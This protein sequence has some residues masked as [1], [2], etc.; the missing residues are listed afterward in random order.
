MNRGIKIIISFLLVTFILLNVKAQD[1]LNIEKIE[2][3]KSYRPLMGDALKTP[4]KPTL[5][6]ASKIENEV[7]Y[8]VPVV[9]FNFT[10]EPQKIKAIA[11]PK[12]KKIKFIPSHIRAGIGAHAST[13]LEYYYSSPQSKEYRY[14]TYFNHAALSGAKKIRNYSNNELAVF[15]EKHFDDFT[16]NGKVKYDRNGV[17]L[18]SNS[19]ATDSIESTPF[20][21]STVNIYSTIF[22]HKENKATIDYKAS[23]N[24]EM[25]FTNTAYKN[26]KLDLNANA[27]KSLAGDNKFEVDAQFIYNTQDLNNTQWE[28]MDFSSGFEYPSTSQSIL[29]SKIQYQL[30]NAKGKLYLGLKYAGDFAISSYYFFPEI[31]IGKSLLK[32]KIYSYNGHTGNLETNNHNYLLQMNPYLGASNFYWSSLYPSYLVTVN[33]ITYTAFKGNPIK[34]LHYDVKASM[35]NVRNLLLFVKPSADQDFAIK[36]DDGDIFN[37]HSE[38]SYQLKSKLKFVLVADYT[39]Y[40]LD[41]EEHA[42]HLPTISSTLSSYYNLQEKIIVKSDIFYQG[43]TYNEQNNAV[44]TI[45]AILDANVG[46]NYIYHKNLSFFLNLNNI[47]GKTYQRWDQ[48]PTYGVNLMGGFSFSF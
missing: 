33:R 2:V 27:I 5:P 31:Y 41:N 9:P 23:V 38:I 7:K 40:N 3:I 43:V 19:D 10:Y 47:T 34:N 29:S 22:N 32:D 8:R 25:G 42:W 6:A 26:D 44:R 12:Q 18:I 39:D 11:F 21:F 17:Q 30:N 20:Q 48:Y 35:N 28:L 36:S 37:L 4:F 1:S 14:G 16:I 24:Y 13:L 15:G 45:G 46:I